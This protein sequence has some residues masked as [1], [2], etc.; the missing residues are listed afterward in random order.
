M[1]NFRLFACWIL[2]SIALLNASEECCSNQI[3]E[4]E[5]LKRQEDVEEKVDEKEKTTE[6]YKGEFLSKTFIYLL[7]NFCITI[8]F[9][10][11]T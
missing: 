6:D 1:R 8:S 11:K 4:S 10:F 5:Q 7:L 9:I 3:K 2:I